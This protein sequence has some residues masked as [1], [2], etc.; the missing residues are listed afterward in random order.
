MKDSGAGAAINFR[1]VGPCSDLPVRSK[2]WIQT[3]PSDEQS[4]LVVKDFHS[5][6]EQIDRELVS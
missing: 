2:M 3:T 1:F 4:R 6:L 5:E